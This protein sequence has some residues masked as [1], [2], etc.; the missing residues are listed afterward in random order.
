[1]GKGPEC[2]RSELDPSGAEYPPETLVV[3]SNHLMDSLTKVVSGLPDGI[4]AFS[5]DSESHV[6][7]PVVADQRSL[8]EILH[9]VV[10][11]KLQPVNG[12]VQAAIVDH[13]SPYPYPRSYFG[14][15]SN[16]TVLEMKIDE[17]G[18]FMNASF[19]SPFGRVSSFTMSISA[20]ENA[21]PHQASSRVSLCLTEQLH[22]LYLN[23]RGTPGLLSFKECQ[24][25][26]PKEL[27]MVFRD[28]RVP[29]IDG[30]AFIHQ[31]LFEGKSVKPALPGLTFTPRFSEWMSSGRCY[32]VKGEGET[33]KIS[34]EGV[35][36][37]I[38][39]FD[40]GGPCMLK[41]EILGV[42]EKDVSTLPDKRRKLTVIKAR[43]T[44]RRLNDDGSMK[45][46]IRIIPDVCVD[47]DLDF[48]RIWPVTALP[49]LFN[50]A[51][52]QDKS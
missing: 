17:K 6:L 21:G 25:I 42:T 23:Y 41:A 48:L 40:K 50:R 4:S 10:I 2:S 49:A 1:M 52:S 28:G 46:V 7:T 44:T 38:A 26:S 20:G 19:N 16:N 5:Y 39:F 12:I 43:V 3:D 45:I 8:D 11:A 13:L 36:E 27:D 33:L 32:L 14:L 31:V 24:D 18:N 15:S 29:D 47:T 30:Q 9:P 51:L 35:V 34:P 22:Y 37:G